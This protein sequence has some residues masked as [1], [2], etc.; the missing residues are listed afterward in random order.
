MEWGYLHFSSILI[1]CSV[2]F[3]IHFG[4]P[5]FRKPPNLRQLKRYRPGSS[6]LPTWEATFGAGER[7]AK[8]ADGRASWH[9]FHLNSPILH[10]TCFQFLR[11][12]K[13]CDMLNLLT[14]T[15]FTTISPIPT[16]WEQPLGT[17][18]QGTPLHRL[19]L[20]HQWQ[21]RI[22]ALQAFPGTDFLHHR[23]G[24]TGIE[25]GNP[26]NNGVLPMGFRL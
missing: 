7:T 22:V 11:K 6:P 1:E 15:L 9:C 13:A 3:I 10:S 17:N 23:I 19:L 25:T 12:M 14:H 21:G 8:S 24:F 2:I 4:V 26:H 20:S 5:H 18:W 16:Q